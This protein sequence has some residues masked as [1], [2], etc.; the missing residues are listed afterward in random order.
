MPKSHH[1]PPQAARHFRTAYWAFLPCILLGALWIFFQAGFYMVERTLDP[2]ALRHESGNAFVT[3]VPP[4]DWH[5]VLELKSDTP[6]GPRASAVTLYENGIPLGPAH[7]LHA[8]IRSNGEGAYSHWSNELY[9]SSTDNTSPATNGRTYTLKTPLKPTLVAQLI[10]ISSLVLVILMTMRLVQIYRPLFSRRILVFITRHSWPITG[11]VAAMMIGVVAAA[12]YTSPF[13]IVYDPDSWGYVAPAASLIEGHGYNHIYGRP[14]LYPLF[15]YVTAVVG[16]TLSGTVLVQSL[17]YLA[18]AVIV[19]LAI[20]LAHYDGN[21]RS[22]LRGCLLVVAACSGVGI[23]FSYPDYAVFAHSLRPELISGFAGV[24]LLALLLALRRVAQTRL[25][26]L[27]LYLGAVIV[28]AMLPLLKPSWLVTA[29]L[30]IALTMFAL[31][32]NSLFS[33]TAKTGLLLCAIAVPVA[34]QFLEGTLARTSNDPMSTTFGPKT[35]FCG[36]ANL[37]S[38]YLAERNETATSAVERQLGDEIRQ[39]LNQLIAADPGG[40]VLLGID[41]DAC[42]YQTSLDSI[43]AR[44]LGGSPKA[45]ASFYLRTAMNAI[46]HN[47]MDYG[48]RVASQ[49]LFLIGNSIPLSDVVPYGYSD[50]LR[51][52]VKR[53]AGKYKLMADLRTR[54]TALSGSIAGPISFPG[55]IDVL[56]VAKKFLPFLLIIALSCAIIQVLGRTICPVDLSQVTALSLVFGYWLSAAMPVAFTHS[57]DVGRYVVQLWPL[58]VVLLAVLLVYFSQQVSFYSTSFAGNIIRRRNQL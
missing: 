13:H 2:S 10:G 12:I 24:L 38:R 16:T 1:F 51:E 8:T 33:T 42:T 47:P 40:Y 23:F 25:R 57:F 5:G 26:F 44:H 56:N 50:E 46:I 21:E 29:A 9:L 7:T 54:E 31:V 32:R 20:L 18:T 49:Y 6:N 11:T 4:I 39:E 58:T 14:F 52:H 45:A 28:A 30:G 41:L 43:V 34:L 22:V 17:L 55:Y 37:V 3:D 35:L 36:T 53:L 27:F 48:R 19:G 15:V